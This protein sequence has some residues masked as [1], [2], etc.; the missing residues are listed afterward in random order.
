MSIFGDV[1]V[2]IQQKIGILKLNDLKQYS[3]IRLFACANTKSD[4]SKLF[5]II[6]LIFDTLSFLGE[7]DILMN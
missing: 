2:R 4:H 6:L 7:I 1:H 5:K 3:S